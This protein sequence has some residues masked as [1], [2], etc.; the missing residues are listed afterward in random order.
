MRCS[1]RVC[2]N[3]MCHTMELLWPLVFEQPHSINFARYS[4]TKYSFYSEVVT[5]NH[6]LVNR[7]RCTRSNFKLVT[8]PLFGNHCR[9]SIWGLLGM[10]QG[11][12]EHASNDA[13]YIYVLFCITA[14][15]IYKV[16]IHI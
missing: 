2:F 12:S 15:K 14:F 7:L 1:V 11:I 5:E 8:S 16:L 6:E 10:Y 4:I 13:Y 9:K 3:N